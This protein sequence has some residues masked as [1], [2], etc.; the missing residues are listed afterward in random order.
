M[1]EDVDD[2]L[3]NDPTG[4]ETEDETEEEKKLEPKESESEIP[5]TEV[6]GSVTSSE[7]D[8]I[9]HVLTSEQ[10]MV[11]RDEY[12]V[13]CFVTT[14]NRNQIQ[15]GDYTQIPYPGEE[16]EEMFCVVDGL[17]YEPYTDL[18]DKS[19]T[20]SQ[21]S[22]ARELDESEFVLVGELD[23]ISIIEEDGEELERSVVNK[24]PKPDTRVRLARDEDVLR[25]G[26][27]IPSDGVFCGYL[28]VGGDRMEVDGDPFPYYLNNPGIDHETGEIEDGEPAIFRHTLVA[29][30]TGK[31]KTHFTKNLLR[32]FMSDKRYPIENHE[33]GE[34]EKCRLNVVVLDPENEYYEMRDDNPELSDEYAESLK[35]INVGGVDDLEVFIPDVAHTNAPSVS[36]S[37]SFGV[38][39]SL[40]KERPQLLM[41]YDSSDITRGAIEDCVKS[42]FNWVEDEDDE[43][44]TYDGFMSY[45]R[46]REDSLKT[47]HDIGDG[48]W[49]AVMRR[50]KRSAFNAVFDQGMTPIT[51]VT[52]S[53]FREG[54]V[55]VIPTSH[56]RGGKEDLV[57]L[58]ILSLII[59]NK[60][61]DYDVD[62]HIKDTPILVSVDE[63]HNY[64]S[65]ADDIRQSYILR[66]ARE[67]VKQGRKDKLGIMM[68]TQNPED[69]DGDILKQINTNI[70]L[71]L[72]GEV[73]EKVPS[74]PREFKK[75][76]PKFGKG[77]AVVKAPDV[78]AVEV[79]GLPVCV[80]KHGN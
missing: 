20:H 10:I 34:M 29:G 59:E 4:T 26:L 45:L 37:R 55:T 43:E 39:F 50:V 6:S 41:P 40:V 72:R 38:P 53:M 35:G 18:D 12:N 9:G 17:R 56:L 15:L 30:S 52:N 22:R 21:I 68:I 24:I 66:R 73:V 19:D 8:G 67:A 60:I 14:D 74:I 80:T 7:Q 49:G 27:N 51:E 61:D 13:N 32:Q 47:R 5:E 48:T 16:N 65:G 3:E 46:S 11:R 2:L 23:P 36:E 78:E 54:Q 1:S 25:T 69:I 70:F 58:S 64:F 28:S 76:I 44:A 63:A 42:Y 77:Q 79:V 57:V 75:D 33:T 31:G 71:G 62:P